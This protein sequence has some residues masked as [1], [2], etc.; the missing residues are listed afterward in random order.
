MYVDRL[1]RVA[2]YVAFRIV[3]IAFN[4]DAQLANAVT[5][6]LFRIP[7]DAR[8]TGKTNPDIAMLGGALPHERF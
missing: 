3:R 1:D 2:G 4:L 8:K 7:S 5:G 6:R